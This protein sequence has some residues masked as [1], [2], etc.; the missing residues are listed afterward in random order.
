MNY[1]IDEIQ[2]RGQ[3]TCSLCDNKRYARGWC[4]KHY[5]R[6]YAHGDPEIKLRP[7]VEEMRAWYFETPEGWVNDGFW[8]Q[9]DRC[10]RER[11]SLPRVGV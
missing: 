8:E 11:L 9:V 5:C 6:W 3:D 2:R 1:L 10:R 7:S 4:R